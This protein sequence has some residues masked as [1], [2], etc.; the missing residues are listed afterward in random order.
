VL[1]VDNFGR[2]P[3]LAIGEANMAI[4][5]ATIGAIIAVYGGRFNQGY[6]AAG[7]GAVVSASHG[8]QGLGLM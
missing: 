2:K 5:H 8:G 3:L 4:S 1:F 7:N 6:A